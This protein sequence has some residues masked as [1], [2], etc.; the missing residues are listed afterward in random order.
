MP[1]SSSSRV[2]NVSQI[3]THKDTDGTEKEKK[4]GKKN[5]GSADPNKNEKRKKAANRNESKE[6]G[7]RSG[8]REL[9][10]HAAERRVNCS[11]SNNNPNEPPESQSETER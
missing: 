4:K 7:S 8:L 6:S 3:N 5:I 1:A 9:S 11:Q 2:R 10:S